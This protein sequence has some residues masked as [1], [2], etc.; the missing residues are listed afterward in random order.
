MIN[1]GDACSVF[2]PGAVTSIKPRTDSDS[3]VCQP[4]V[5]IGRSQWLDVTQS[6]S[7]LPFLWMSRNDKFAVFEGLVVEVE[8]VAELQNSAKII[9]E[10]LSGVFRMAEDLTG[11]L[12]ESLNPFGGMVE[13]K[14]RFC[15]RS[16][17]GKVRFF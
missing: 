11:Q 13:L 10:G 9:N 5:K 4:I 14:F 12:K 3:L 15:G 8:V 6:E 17:N 16:Q 1:K 7:D 2:H